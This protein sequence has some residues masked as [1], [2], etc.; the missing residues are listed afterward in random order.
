MLRFG[1]FSV[2][3]LAAFTGVRAEPDSK[4]LNVPQELLQKRLEAAKNVYSRNLDRVRKGQ[5][6]P[7]ELFG[8]S[9]HWLKAELG[10]IEKKVD[11]QRA[12]QDHLDR[13]REI[14]RVAINF[15]KSGQGRQADADAATFY[16]VEAEIHLLNEGVEPRPAKKMNKE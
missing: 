4:P 6:T 16:R 3:L 5:G 14:E 8:W 10:L 13:T 2:I 1:L 15:A 11:R 9:E 7:N 12:L